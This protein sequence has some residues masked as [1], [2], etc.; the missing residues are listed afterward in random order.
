MSIVTFWRIAGIQATTA[1]I[2]QKE[3]TTVATQ[4]ERGENA[5]PDRVEV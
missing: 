4:E 2:E 3:N 1:R 5:A